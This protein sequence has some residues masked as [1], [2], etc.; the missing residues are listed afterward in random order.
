[1]STF[2]RQLMMQ[3]AARYIK[4]EDPNAELLCLKY[5]DFDNDG[6]ISFDDLEKVVSIGDNFKNDELCKN[7]IKFNEFKFFTAKT[8]YLVYS[9]FEKFI[10]LEEI[11]LPPTLKTLPNRAFCYIYRNKIKK[12][13]IPEGVE[14]IGELCFLG[15]FAPNITVKIPSTIKFIGT[16]AFS[17][18]KGITFIFKGKVPPNI[19]NKDN[20]GYSKNDQTKVVVGY[21]PDESLEFYKN[22]GIIGNMCSDILPISEYKEK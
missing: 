18:Q 21:A 15:A 3:A 16:D 4:F 2:R 6:R 19:E 8:L 12:I 9:C 17:W 5:F 11:E 20:W 13:I 10:N 1:M 7:V 22:S 14:K